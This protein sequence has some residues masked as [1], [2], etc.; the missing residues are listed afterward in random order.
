MNDPPTITGVSATADRLTIRWADGAVS[1]LPSLW[2]RDNRPDDRDPHSGQRLVDIADV[3][4]SPRLAS[5]VLA[6]EGV[7]IEWAGEERSALFN[8]EWLAEHA[9]GGARSPELGARTWL[10]GATLD[11]GRDFAWANPPGLAGNA[12][13]RLEWLTRAAA[14]RTRLSAARC[15]RKKG[16]SS[17]PCPSSAACSRPTTD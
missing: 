8:K 2:L 1:E 11:A 5:A 9:R 16:R 13:L 7:Q 14:G 17:R 10:E 12:R 6:P 4:E 15:P 3:P